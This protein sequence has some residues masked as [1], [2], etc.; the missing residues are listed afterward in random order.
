VRQRVESR[1]G[2]SDGVEGTLVYL[3]AVADVEQ[4][5]KEHI[6]KHVW[7]PFVRGAAGAPDGDRREPHAPLTTMPGRTAAR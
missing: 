6:A 5:D 2:L 7:S 1:E 4:V 3:L